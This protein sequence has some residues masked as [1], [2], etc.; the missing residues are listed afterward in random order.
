[1]FERGELEGAWVPEPWAARM[2]GAG[3]RILV[4]ERDLWPERRFHTTVI[5][6]TQR[7]LERRREDI[8]KLLRAHVVLTRTWQQ[9]PSAFVG[10]VAAAFKAHAG[11]ELA[12]RVL[13]DAFSRLEPAVRPDEA[14]VREVARHAR[15]LGYVATDDVSGIVDGSLLD[16]VMRDLGLASASP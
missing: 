6:T 10:A 7:A 5:V 11:K 15:E 8:K 14:H 1:M 3:G 16:E 2:L 12:P 4:D 13:A 9:D